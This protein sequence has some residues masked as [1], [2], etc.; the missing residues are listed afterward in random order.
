MFSTIFFK[1]SILCSIP[2]NFENWTKLWTYFIGPQSYFF[3]SL[4]Q[5]RFFFWIFIVYLRKYWSCASRKYHPHLLTPLGRR[6]LL[7]SLRGAAS[8]I[9]YTSI[10]KCRNLYSPIL[11]WGSHH[12]L[13]ILYGGIYHRY[14]PQVRSSV[15]MRW[16]IGAVQRLIYSKRR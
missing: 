6:K 12:Y 4:F 11:H 8:N 15:G 10:K 9:H 1:G 3:S 7:C 14:L 16:R 5:L 2:T 13:F